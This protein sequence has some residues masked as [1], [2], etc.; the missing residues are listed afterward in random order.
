MRESSQVMSLGQG[1]GKRKLIYWRCVVLLGLALTQGC[2][3]IRRSM[4]ASVVLDAVC[5]PFFRL[6]NL[7]IVF[8]MPPWAFIVHPCAS[9]LASCVHAAEQ[10]SLWGSNPRPMA[11]KTIA[12]TTELRELM[13]TMEH[14]THPSPL[15]RVVAASC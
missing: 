7:I 15:S 14:V 3:D 1:A 10:Y 9:L 4:F 6:S 13:A 2:S 5:L 8:V 11:H 12:L